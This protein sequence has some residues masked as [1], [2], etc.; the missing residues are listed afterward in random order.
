MNFTTINNLIITLTWV[1][2]SPST[3]LFCLTLRHQSS[4]RQSS[5]RELNLS[6]SLQVCIVGKFIIAGC[7]WNILRDIT[8][9][10]N[11]AF[12]GRGV[13]GFSYTVLATIPQQKYWH[14]VRLQSAGTL[15]TI[16][17]EQRGC[18]NS[19][20]SQLFSLVFSKVPW[21]LPEG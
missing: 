9:L 10:N 16:K 8:A 15:S 14:R 17:E 19:W 11:K 1:K 4:S 2:C 21:P 3:Y 7:V 6:T 12:S 13:G 20:S 5:Q 18:L